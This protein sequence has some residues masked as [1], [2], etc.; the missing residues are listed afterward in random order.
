MKK[1]LWLILAFATGLL[2]GFFLVFN[3]M[4]S[5]VISPYERGLSFLVVIVTY[6]VL[7]AAFGLTGHDNGRKLGILIS[8]PALILAFIY[9]IKETGTISINFLYSAAALV[10]SVTGSSLGSKLSK[11]R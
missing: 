10:S 8:L 4:F 3:F 9:S 6:L 11:K 5:D 7:G 1:T 2:P